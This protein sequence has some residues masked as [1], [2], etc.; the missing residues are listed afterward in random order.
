MLF[1]DEISHC[2]GIVEE[3]LSYDGDLLNSQ[4]G[5]SLGNIKSTSEALDTLRSYKIDI[6]KLH[7]KFLIKLIEK[8]NYKDSELEAWKYYNST[9]LACSLP[10]I[11]KQ[12]IDHDLILKGI[13]FDRINYGNLKYQYIGFMILYFQIVYLSYKD[14]AQLITDEQFLLKLLNYRKSNNFLNF[15]IILSES[16]LESEQ[17]FFTS[18]IKL[19]SKMFNSFLNLKNINHVLKSKI[20]LTCFTYFLKFDLKSINIENLVKPQLLTIWFNKFLNEMKRCCASFNLENNRGLYVQTSSELF[21]FASQYSENFFFLNLKHLYFLIL[22]YKKIQSMIQVNDGLIWDRIILLMS[23]INGI[24]LPETK[25]NG[26]T[27]NILNTLKKESGLKSN[28]KT[29]DIY[30]FDEL[31]KLDDFRHTVIHLNLSSTKILQNKFNLAELEKVIKKIID[32]NNYQNILEIILLFKKYYFDHYCLRSQHI[33]ILDTLTIYIKEQVSLVSV[34]LNDD[35]DETILKILEALSSLFYENIKSSK[36]NSF[37]FVKRLRNISNLY[38]NI[39]LRTHNKKI[40]ENSIHIESLLFTFKHPQKIFLLSFSGF[41]EDLRQYYTKILKISKVLVKL[42]RYGEALKIVLLFIISIFK[43][44]LAE[45]SPRLCFAKLC[46]IGNHFK[47]IFVILMKSLVNDLESKLFV[48]ESE[49][50]RFMNEIICINLLKF[51]NC[52]KISNAIFQKYLDSFSYCENDGIENKNSPVN[53]SDIIILNNSISPR[54]HHDMITNLPDPKLFNIC[55]W[56]YLEKTSDPITRIKETLIISRILYHLNSTS[57]TSNHYNSFII[58]LI[59]QKLIEYGTIKFNLSDHKIFFQK[60]EYFFLD[61]LEP[62]NELSREDQD[63][64]YW[65]IF[66]NDNIL[67]FISALNNIFPLTVSIDLMSRFLNSPYGS[68]YSLENFQIKIMLIDCCN[69]LS[70]Y[71]LSPSCSLNNHFSTQIVDDVSSSLSDNYQNFIKDDLSVA[72]IHIKYKLALLTSDLLQNK[73]ITT[74]MTNFADSFEENMLEKIKVLFLLAK[75]YFKLGNCNV[76]LI[77]SNLKTSLNLIRDILRRSSTDLN[78]SL[79]EKN[80]LKDLFFEIYFFI[81]NTHMHFGLIKDCKY[82]VKEISKVIMTINGNDQ[83]SRDNYSV[84]IKILNFCKIFLKLFIYCEENEIDNLFYMS[85]GL[86]SLDQRITIDELFDF[87]SELHRNFLAIFNFPSNLLNDNQIEFYFLTVLYYNF[88]EK[89][90]DISSS[91]ICTYYSLFMNSMKEKNLSSR[92]LEYELNSRLMKL[93]KSDQDYRFLSSTDDVRNMDLC[94]SRRILPFLKFEYYLI[95]KELSLNSIFSLI[96]DTS[97]SLPSISNR[98]FPLD[99]R[100]ANDPFFKLKRFQKMQIYI[101]KFNS[102]LFNNLLTTQS[103]CNIFELSYIYMC[104]TALLYSV[105]SKTVETTNYF[106]RIEE[107]PRYLPFAYERAVNIQNQILDMKLIDQALDGYK[108]FIPK[109]WNIISIDLCPL[110]NDL[111]LTKLNGSYF[112]VR[113]PLTRF[114]SRNVSESILTFSD[115]IQYFNNLISQNN[116]TTR[117]ST[118]NKGK[119]IS[120]NDK[121]QWWKSRYQLNMKLS[122]LLENIENCW[123]GG[124][125]GLFGMV[126]HEG[127]VFDEFKRKLFRVFDAYLPSRN[128]KNKSFGSINSAFIHGSD[129][130]TFDTNKDTIDSKLCIDDNLVRLFMTLKDFKDVNLLEDLIYFVLDTLS[131]H[132]EVNAYDEINL[133]QIYIELEKMI[134]SYSPLLVPDIKHIVLVI[135][136]DCLML[137]WESLPCLQGLSVSRMPCLTL[138]IEQLK[139]NDI[140][141]LRSDN[142]ALILNPNKDLIKTEMTFKPKINKFIP[143]SWDCLVSKEP[144]ESQFLSFLENSDFL[145]YIGHGGGEQFISNTK[146][147]MLQKCAS[148]FLAGCSSGNLV[149]NGVFEPYGLV[150]SYLIGGSPLVVANL[151]DVTDKDIDKFTISVFEKW[152]LFSENSGQETLNICQAV[153]QSRDKC[154]LK[155]LNGAAPVVYGLPFILDKS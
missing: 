19:I 96:E 134:V 16:Q 119:D 70:S 55:Y 84:S 88:K 74:A 17:K 64:D 106:V 34:S 95:K 145:A 78:L 65:T 71:A 129:K 125:K 45:N 11:E 109:S 7:K 26:S 10:N 151:W 46:Q 98:I 105:C 72:N 131:F 29:I 37:Q 48:S 1:S 104:M 27:S 136:K 79:T 28:E 38:Y 154:I 21:L 59:I 62:K 108:N 93:L 153:S 2:T 52:S 54:I 80:N 15:M 43:C 36:T 94:D 3:F 115:A 25:I 118:L 24:Q 68:Y 142:N 121:K 77:I 22:E 126:D 73:E 152:G 140:M 18:T 100:N 66:K 137:P 12:T 8:Q 149:R 53:D 57:S 49:N 23:K 138:L 148:V 42:S 120:L 97:I 150:H 40:F 117:F 76:N 116:E 63:Y 4:S 51:S 41:D 13:P 107:I 113:L 86:K 128:S 30:T 127:P 135:G 133:E 82:Y 14:N 146:L 123:L 67:K 130:S 56:K 83:N 111:V 32:E 114:N 90:A 58:S 99:S 122:K 110:T 102:G 141:K 101:E 31:L 92:L 39:G 87:Y 124:F 44:D 60:L 20:V 69:S 147:K 61:W 6:N 9:F 35:F 103:T 33:S 132:G 85:A 112:N 50:L 155:Y 5:T 89:Q 139:K 81:I 47:D 91:K 75:Y 144:S 143:Q